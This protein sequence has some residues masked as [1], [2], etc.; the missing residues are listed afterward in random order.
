MTGL[1]YLG[2]PGVQQLLHKL[3]DHLDR[4]VKNGCKSIRALK[5]DEKT[6]P[7]LYRAPFE[8]DKE[9]LWGYVEQ[10]AKL[11][12]IQLKLERGLF[13]QAGYA[14]E[15]RV[16]VM[17][18]PSIR[19]AT[20]RL[21]RIKASLELWQEAVYAGLQ[22]PKETQDLVAR[23]PIDIPGRTSV[24]IVNQFG[25]LP[26]LANRPLLLREVSCRL[27]WGG[28]KILDG[29]GA[30]IAAILNTE[31]CPFAEMPIH[32]QVHLP[33]Q[34]FDGVL[35]I[36]N[37]TTFEQAMR[38]IGPR[39]KNLALIFASGFKSSARRLRQ[40][41]GASVFFSEHGA[42]EVEPKSH[43]LTWLRADSELPCWFWGDL[44]YSGMGILSTLRNSFGTIQAWQPGYGPM[45]DILQQGGGHAPVEAGKSA[46]RA[47]NATECPYADA[48]LLPALRLEGRFVDQEMV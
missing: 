48:V 47:I 40:P 24:E 5:L 17:D 27:F 3:M 44:D 12:W 45:L 16:V 34:G 19:Q 42:T 4:A 30:L 18:E 22:A 26:E 8:S 7:S 41:I 14:L 23:C 37:Q 10:L 6:F 36:E 11:G 33:K 28:S 43:F 9:E 38:D 13:G 2:H 39:F 20:G 25:L 15:P 31:E 32:L 1:P 35:F 46:Q 21:S 29:K